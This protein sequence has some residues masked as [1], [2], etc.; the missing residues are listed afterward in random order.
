MPLPGARADGAVGMWLDKKSPSVMKGWQRRWFVF[1]PS[2]D[3]FYFTDPSKESASG[4]KDKKG[5]GGETKQMFKM[6]DCIQ[7]SS[8]SKARVSTQAVCRCLFLAI[9]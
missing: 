4:K 6:K 9:F 8:Q 2:G 5:K 1:H 7:I 3:T